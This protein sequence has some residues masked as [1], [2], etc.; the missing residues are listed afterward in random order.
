MTH[1]TD[2]D[3]PLVS[4][5][6][7]V[8]DSQFSASSSAGSDSSAAHARY[9]ST[10]G[11]RAAASDSKPWVQVDLGEAVIVA[12]IVTQAFEVCSQ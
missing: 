9:G 3:K 2:C 8:T 11:W 7:S 6:G 1:Y 5:I 10:L 4:D 12:G